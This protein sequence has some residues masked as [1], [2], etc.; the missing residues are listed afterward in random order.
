MSERSPITP[1]DIRDAAELVAAAV[2]K[3]DPQLWERDAY[4]LDWS[5]ARTVSHIGDALA[6]YSKSL[7]SRFQENPGSRGLQY[8]E[9]TQSQAAHQLEY[10]AAILSRVAEAT[11]SDIRAF[12][13][14]GM[15]DAEGF[16]GMGCIEILLH[17][18]DAVYGTEAEF[19]PSD[20]L[21][22]RVLQRMFPWAPTDTPPWPT[23]LWATGRAELDGQEFLGESW[24]WHSDLLEEWEGGIP[25]SRIWLGR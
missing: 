8:S 15:P 2:N 16:L 4:G 14:S 9:G 20:E 1:Q 10:G 19:D 18:Y 24:I 17:G 12:H 6:F 21:C 3:L 25:N 23:L 7:A 13:P 22:S 11:P 5:R